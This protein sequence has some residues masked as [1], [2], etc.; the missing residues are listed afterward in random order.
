VDIPA[1]AGKTPVQ[2]GKAEVPSGGRE[3]GVFERYDAVRGIL[4]DASP[5]NSFGFSA[6]GDRAIDLCE[7]LLAVWPDVCGVARRLAIG[8]GPCAYPMNVRSSSTGSIGKRATSSYGA[9]SS[10]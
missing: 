4:G 6:G 8:S 9:H 2:N 10:S 5:Q 3:Q 1:T 7:A